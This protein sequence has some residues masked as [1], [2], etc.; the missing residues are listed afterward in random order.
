MFADFADFADFI[1]GMFDEAI[2]G[3]VAGGMVMGVSVGWQWRDGRV[4][5][6]SLVSLSQVG[7][8]GRHGHAGDSFRVVGVSASY[9]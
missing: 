5:M 7:T 9:H 4:A 3:E 6:R 1:A 2:A 8:I